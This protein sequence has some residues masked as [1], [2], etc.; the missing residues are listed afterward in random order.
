M[1]ENYYTVDVKRYIGWYAP[2]VTKRRGFKLWMGILALSA[3]MT[4][5]GYILNAGGKIISIGWML[6]FIGCYRGLFFDQVYARRQFY[7]I[8]RS[9]D[10]G[11]EQLWTR[12][13]IAHADGVE[14]YTDD[15]ICLSIRWN[16]VDRIREDEHHVDIHSGENIVRFEKDSFIEG[17]ADEFSL[18]LE[19][20]LPNISIERGIPQYLC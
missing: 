16:E 14:S 4:L 5:M 1:F 12:R 18:W 17:T 2:P 9:M 19:E 6:M 7:A 10:K 3:V 15:A 20:K 8:C 13:N 11:G